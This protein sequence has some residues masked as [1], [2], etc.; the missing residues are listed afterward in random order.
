MFMIK[1]IFKRVIIF[2]FVLFL[3]LA[4]L[5]RGDII[6]SPAG[7]VKLS[8]ADGFSGNPTITWNPTSKRFAVFWLD[9]RSGDWEIFFSFIKSD[10]S[11][12]KSQ[13]KIDYKADSYSLPSVAYIGGSSSYGLIWN[14]NPV[15]GNV[16]FY[17][18]IKSDATMDN[19]TILKY[20]TGI[21]DK[22]AIV[23]RGSKFGVAFTDSAVDPSLNYIYFCE[24]KSDG[25]LNTPPVNLCNTLSNNSLNSSIATDESK[26]AVAFSNN[27]GEIYEIYVAIMDSDGGID[28]LKKISENCSNGL[29]PDIVYGNNEYGLVYQ[30][31]VGGHFDIFFQRVSKSGSKNGGRF[32][33]SS[34]FG[35]S[36]NPQIVFNGKEYGVVW[37]DDS[38]GS[39]DIFFAR[40]SSEGQLIEPQS[41]IAGADQALQNPDISWSGS[42]Y[43]Y[44]I[45]WHKYD[46]SNTEVYFT[47]VKIR[48]QSNMF[49]LY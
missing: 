17:E 24:V 18:R 20:L 40:I 32:N 48:D 25:A 6:V 21:V 12:D 37:Q 4:Q 29:A 14:G 44:G 3:V 26:Y 16:L 43:G 5:C 39:S 15:L 27:S 49:Y 41:V 22:S 31:Q 19:L 11:I 8:K 42:N 28:S 36:K 47:T 7:P 33:I 1:Y 13:K 46:S 2:N 35:D 45:T 30:D 10:S 34:N 23:T 38:L 9:N